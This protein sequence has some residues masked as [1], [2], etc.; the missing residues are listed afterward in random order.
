L[1]CRSWSRRGGAPRTAAP[2]QPSWR[3]KTVLADQTYEQ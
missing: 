2:V 3:G 1:R